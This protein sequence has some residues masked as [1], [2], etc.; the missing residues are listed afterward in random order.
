[1]LPVG[2]LYLYQARARVAQAVL[3]P[4]ALF[5]PETL[6]LPPC[7]P[8]IPL[9]LAPTFGVFRILGG[10]F[11]SPGPSFG[12]WFFFFSLFSLQKSSGRCK[13]SL[14]TSI[15][16]KRIPFSPPPTTPEF[17]TKVFRMQGEPGRRKNCSHCNFQ[18]FHSLNKENQVSLVRTFLSEPSSGIIIGGLGDWEWKD[19]PDWIT[20]CQALPH[21]FCRLARVAV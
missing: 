10:G 16:C 13:R 1:M 8:Q 12:D 6:T 18:D 11:G 14:I 21:S 15:L 17:L 5:H 4:G 19:D 9:V 3:L 2:A 20:C 7:P